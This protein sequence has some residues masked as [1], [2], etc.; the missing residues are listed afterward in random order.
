M[1]KYNPDW[2]SQIFKSFRL[3]SFVFE[4]ARVTFVAKI[5]LLI[6]ISG[7]SRKYG[8]NKKKLV[9]LKLSAV[10]RS[11][12]WCYRDFY[13]RRNRHLVV[14]IK[15]R[16]LFYKKNV[17]KV[18]IIFSTPIPPCQVIFGT[19]GSDWRLTLNTL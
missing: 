10:Y 12:S 3:E 2:A 5:N 8:T 13:Y 7:I 14:L 11:F 17:W 6:K 9:E 19:Q 1:H 15:L 18:L 16:L 4:C